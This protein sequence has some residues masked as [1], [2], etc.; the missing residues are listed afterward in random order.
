MAK[1]TIE[2]R[3]LMD[4]PETY[5]TILQ[6]MSTYPL[7]EKKSQEEHMPSYVPTRTQLNDKILNRY[8][9]REIG[10]ES[11][12][13]FI[14]ELEIALNE[15]MPKYNQL[16]YTADLDYDLLY[17]VDYTRTTEIKK[18][19]ES[20][21]NGKSNISSNENSEVNTDVNNYNKN[22][23]SDTPQGELSTPGESINDVSHASEVTWN[24]DHNN[25]KST[26]KG[27]ASSDTTSDLKGTSKEDELHS[28]I[29]KGNYGQVSFQHLINAYR[30]LI[31]NIEQEIINDKRISDLFMKIY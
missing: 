2:L 14:D 5:K 27:S 18:T 12:G 25:D 4:D 15:I 1:Y 11:V 9:Y 29:I 16:F 8:K 23:K 17:N 19:G 20:A 24:H 28:E 6:A 7:Y 10:F 13:R 3:T 22:V 21:S 26:S 30:E 31:R